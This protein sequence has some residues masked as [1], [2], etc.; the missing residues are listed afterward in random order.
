MVFYAPF[1]RVHAL[2]AEKANDASVKVEL[3]CENPRYVAINDA[4]GRWIA[5][6]AVR[7]RKCVPCGRMRMRLWMQ[8]AVVEFLASERSWWITYTF[9][10]GAEFLPYEEVKKS[11]KGRRKRHQFRFLCSEEEGERN[12]RRHFHV[13]YH[14]SEQLQRRDRKSVV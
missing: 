2:V 4:E 14:C 3:V 11:H 12:G 1:S 7:C 6:Q 5:H 8:R 10:P 13:L 9:R